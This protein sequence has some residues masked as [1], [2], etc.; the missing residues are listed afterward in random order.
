MADELW[1]KVVLTWVDERVVAFDDDD[2]NR[3]DAYRQGHLDKAAPPADELP[4]VLDG[5]SPAAAVERVAAAFAG[6]FQGALDVTLLGMGP[7]GHIASLFPGR[8]F[9]GEGPVVH[10]ANSPKPPPDRLS[11]TRPVLATA[12]RAILLAAGES[13]R[14]ALSRVLDGDQALPATGLPGLTIVTD[15]QGLDARN[16]S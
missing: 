15:V 13:K 9:D 6:R 7:D 2:S 3:G 14:E 16:A 5:E 4:L 12:S 8:P 1:S 11:L 10:V